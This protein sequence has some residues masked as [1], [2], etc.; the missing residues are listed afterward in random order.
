MVS[1]RGDNTKKLEII[2]MMIMMIDDKSVSTGVAVKL[3]L[4]KVT[5]QFV[6]VEVWNKDFS[7]EV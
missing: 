4:A 7:N 6:V 5:T 2:M 1:P 3:R